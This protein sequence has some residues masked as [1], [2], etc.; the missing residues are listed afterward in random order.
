MIFDNIPFEIKGDVLSYLGNYKY[1]KFKNKIE[2]VLQISK[3]KRMEVQILLS[4]ISKIYVYE[5]KDG[6]KAYIEFS[7]II[8]IWR[9]VHKNEELEASNNL[10]YYF[11]ERIYSNHIY[12]VP[13]K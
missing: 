6:W 1:R 3:E 8:P 13:I 9:I 12:R 10:I 7:N 4:K 5:K 2:F 11:Y